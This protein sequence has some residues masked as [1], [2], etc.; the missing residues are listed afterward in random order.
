MHVISTVHLGLVKDGASIPSVSISGSEPAVNFKV[1]FLKFS[2]KII[3]ENPTLAA[4]TRQAVAIV[5]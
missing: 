5:T 1:S 4:C 2:R 3:S